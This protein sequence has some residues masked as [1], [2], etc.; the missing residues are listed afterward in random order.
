MNL[1]IFS[2][3]ASQTWNE[4]IQNSTNGTIFH[5]W[6]WLKVAEKHS[7]SKLLPLVF[8][9]DDKPFGAIPLFFMKKMG[10]RFIFSPPPGT[11]ITLGPVLIDKGY[12]RRE[13]EMAYLD[14]EDSFD[15]L[16][17]K[18]K[19][20]YLSII[21]SPGLL[22][23]RPFLWNKFE[24]APSY[25]YKIDLNRGK[26]NIWRDLSQSLKTNIKTGQ[27]QGITI[28]ERNDLQSIEQVYASLKHRYAQQ[29]RNIPMKMDYLKDLVS[30]F[31]QP[32]IKTYLAIYNGEIVGSDMCLT[33]KDTTVSWMGGCRSE[34]NKIK[35]NEFLR[36]HEI[37]EAIQNGSRWFEIEGANTVQLCD[38]KS[39]FNPHISI[40]FVLKRTDL[41]GRLAE[42]VYTM[43]SSSN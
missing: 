27:K 13:F 14:F 35:A 41:I 16:L 2:Q 36:W 3:N 28:I 25:T 15:R 4:I 33:D 1:E 18:I 38:S 7:G 10:L 8:F 29:D 12:K 21:T 6:D 20:N 19:P 31:G 32:A 40:Y 23:M 30:E 11:G 37:E 42:K 5:T 39:R 17:K 24:V 43:K 34:S 22:D 9:D 26:E